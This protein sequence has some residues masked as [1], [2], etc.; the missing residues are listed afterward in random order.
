MQVIT[1]AINNRA[2]EARCVVMSVIEE[3]GN[4]KLMKCYRKGNDIQSQL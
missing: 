3:A 4:L 1:K 2:R